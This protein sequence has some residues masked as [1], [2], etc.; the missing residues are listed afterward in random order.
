MKRFSS[1]IYKSEDA[2]DSVSN[3]PDDFPEGVLKKNVNWELEMGEP[4]YTIDPEYRTIS[5]NGF[6]YFA[7]KILPCVNARRT[8]FKVK[9]RKEA[10]SDIF[11]VSDE[12]YA[13]ALL[14]NEYD[15]YQFKLKTDDEVGVRPMKPF[16]SSAS[17]SKLG[18]NTMGRKTYIYLC[19]KVK[20]LRN[21]QVLKNIEDTMLKGF[22]DQEKMRK[23]RKRPEKN[24]YTEEEDMECTMDQD[25]DL[26]KAIFAAV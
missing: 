10:L 19:D 14:I 25:S 21:N 7:T 13:L 23:K 18:W 4:K 22:Q 16:T 2:K 6:L 26:F 1:P 20:T 15:S 24:V 9:R 8:N 12:A 3:I 17:G 5:S 11:T